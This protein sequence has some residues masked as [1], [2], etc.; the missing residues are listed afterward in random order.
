M[1]EGRYA[2]L[3]KRGDVVVVNVPG[4]EP[5][6]AVVRD[7]DMLLHLADGTDYRVHANDIVELVPSDIPED[8]ATQVEALHSEG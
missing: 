1:N 6:E 5:R 2:R 3:L 7:V 8:L 4:N